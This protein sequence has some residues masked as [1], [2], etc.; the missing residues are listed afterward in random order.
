[1]QQAGWLVVPILLAQ[2][3]QAAEECDQQADEYECM[4]DFVDGLT[5]EMAAEAGLDGPPAELN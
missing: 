3:S 1:M 5:A 4:A 2:W